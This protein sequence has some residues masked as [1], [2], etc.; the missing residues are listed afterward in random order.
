MLEKSSLEFA[1][2]TDSSSAIAIATPYEMHGGN[3]SSDDESAGG[4]DRRSLI[5]GAH[6]HRTS[7]PTRPSHGII[8]GGS[9]SG[10]HNMCSI[11]QALIVMSAIFV[12]VNNFV[13][14]QG[15]NSQQ[16]K[17]I[18]ID[19]LSAEVSQLR[20]PTGSRDQ[21]TTSS[22]ASQ[23][24]S[25]VCITGQLS[26]L[27][28][29]NKIATVLEPLRQAGL[30]PDIALVVDDSISITTNDQRIEAT[31]RPA[32][33]SFQDVLDEL[34][35]YQY[36]VLTDGPYHQPE[37][38]LVPPDYLK[39]LHHRSSFDANKTEERAANNVRMME[40][41]SQCY[42]E[43][44]RDVERM[45]SYDVVMRIREDTGFLSAIDFDQVR[46]DLRDDPLAMINN[47]CRA[48]YDGHAMN[49]KMGITSRESARAYF[50]LPFHNMYA[51][52]IL[53]G[54]KNTE[55]FF[56]ETYTNAGYHVTRSTHIR[57]VVK[58]V[59]GDD[60]TTM[61]FHQER[62]KLA[63]QCQIAVEDDSVP[64]ACTFRWNDEEG[65]MEVDSDVCWSSHVIDDVLEEEE[66]EGGESDDD[67]VPSEG[68][69]GG[70]SG[71]SDE[72][73]NDD[74]DDVRVKQ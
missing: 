25:F 41:W 7:Q 61:L 67:D 17:V 1:S 39:Y 24:R 66:E 63:K 37:Q 20:G 35:S 50:E 47:G 59:S 73:D 40:S 51:E 13:S 15:Q 74:D 49:D 43:M 65:R 8:R 19:S 42:V 55:R 31:Y 30:P 26:R 2:A 71:S 68:G 10:R 6:T 33:G 27:E 21:N 52:P 72:D 29:Q 32:Y 14:D 23:R 58:L 62:K 48:W 44:S 28:M 53:D 18:D 69:G 54:M 12:L 60:G 11:F 57:D 46:Q 56:Y 3:S 16:Q 5:G 34:R 38:V 22:T 45:A 4:E 36:N 9:V 64:G 70:G